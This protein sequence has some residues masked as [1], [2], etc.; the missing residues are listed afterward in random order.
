MKTFI[1]ELDPNYQQIIIF[2]GY[3]FILQICLFVIQVYFLY[4]NNLVSKYF[5]QVNFAFSF[6]QINKKSKLYRLKQLLL[7]GLK[8]I[9]KISFIGVLL[10]FY[11]NNKSDFIIVVMAITIINLASLCQI[12]FN[13]LPN[14]YINT[15]YPEEINLKSIF[16]KIEYKN[17]L[18]RTVPFLLGFISSLIIIKEPYFKKSIWIL[19]VIAIF[20]FNHF[21]I[22]TSKLFIA[23]VLLNSLSL[24]ILFLVFGQYV[25]KL[26]QKHISINKNKFNN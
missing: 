8:I 19:I 22:M 7:F 4:K 12:N 2:V 24:I 11:R 3:I 6:L 10:A 18:Y 5:T 25:I 17:F 20:P 16:F 13:H 1:G 15:I 23:S 14:D 26:N 21:I 9:F